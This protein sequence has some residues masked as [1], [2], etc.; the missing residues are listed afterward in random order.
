MCVKHDCLFTGEVSIRDGDERFGQQS[1]SICACT[2]VCVCKYHHVS[3][4]ELTNIQ[5]G[6]PN[7]E[8]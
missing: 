6:G 8:N 7:S 2:C 4:P 3:H 1:V 5:L